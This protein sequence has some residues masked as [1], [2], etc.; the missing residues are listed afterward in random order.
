M[1]TIHHE[2][3]DAF[4]HN[5]AFKTPF[6][7]VR[8]QDDHLFLVTKDGPIMCKKDGTIYI[9]VKRINRP[10]QRYINA[11]LKKHDSYVTTNRGWSHLVTKPGCSIAVPP[12]W[13]V[14]YA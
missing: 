12:T 8:R 14:S 3:A 2:A 5:I 6:V 11:V 4:N 7:E 10:K 9:L 13:E 1:S